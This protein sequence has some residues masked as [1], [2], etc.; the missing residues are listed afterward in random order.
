MVLEPQMF[1]FIVTN[2]NLY[3]THKDNEYVQYIQTIII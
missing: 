3:Y 2:F 1:L